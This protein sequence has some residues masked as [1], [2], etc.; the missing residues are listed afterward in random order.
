[1]LTTNS[2]SI[3][4]EKAREQ[5]KKNGIIQTSLTGLDEYFILDNNKMTMKNEEI[6]DEVEGDIKEVSKQFKK[7]SQNKKNSRVFA[8]KLLEVISKGGT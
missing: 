7:K 3:D 8:R 4:D 2:K 1:M 6:D 5:I